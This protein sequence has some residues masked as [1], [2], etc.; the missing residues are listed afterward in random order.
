MRVALTHAV[1]R[2]A[3]AR[4][5]ANR[6]VP[7]QGPVAS[8]VDGFNRDLPESAYDPLKARALLVLFADSAF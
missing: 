8:M 1:D 5:L 6:R 2:G 7:T 4:L 3:L